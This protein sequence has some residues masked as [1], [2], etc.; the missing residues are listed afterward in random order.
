MQVGAGPPFQNPP[1]GNLESAFGAS[2]RACS[3]GPGDLGKRDSDARAEPLLQATLRRLTDELSAVR[4]RTAAGAPR[5][6][7]RRDRARPLLHG[8][9]GAPA[10]LVA[11]LRPG[12]LLP[13]VLAPRV[14]AA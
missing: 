13:V 8:Q 7:G 4:D 5:Q 11:H 1:V 3:P 12:L 10:A 14:R 2:L 6:A 9:P